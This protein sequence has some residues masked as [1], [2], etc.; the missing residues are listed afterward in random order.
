MIALVFPIQL[1]PTEL[2]A[3]NIE[4]RHLGSF[5]GTIHTALPGPRQGLTIVCCQGFD[6]ITL[7]ARASQAHKSHQQQ[8]KAADQQDGV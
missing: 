2:P 1:R 7:P 6:D 4:G 3:Q 8:Q 5:L